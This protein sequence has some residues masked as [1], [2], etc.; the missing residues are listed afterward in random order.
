MVRQRFLIRN[1]KALWALLQCQ[2]I[3]HTWRLSALLILFEL[4]Y[5]FLNRL[6]WAKGWL[7]LRQKR[8]EMGLRFSIPTV[9]W[10]SCLDVLIRIL[11]PAS[12]TCMSSLRDKTEI[13]TLMRRS[14][15][16]RVHEAYIYKR[17]ET[18]VS[19]WQKDKERKSKRGGGQTGW[20]TKRLLL[21][22][23]AFQM[24]HNASQ[25]QRTMHLTAWRFFFQLNQ[26]KHLQNKSFLSNQQL[27]G[28]QIKNSIWTYQQILPQGYELLY[29]KTRHLG[30]TRFHFPAWQ[31]LSSGIENKNMKKS[32][33]CNSN[34]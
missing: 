12:P 26:D 22:K 27:Y 24:A 3:N 17:N 18:K 4:L 31:E 10:Q 20:L 23:L 1:S 25:D 14:K 29:M 30:T 28:S 5:R 19:F 15:L 16:C 9:F 8:F 6:V 2:W 11:R 34:H 32:S 21:K 7:Y 13:C 33:D